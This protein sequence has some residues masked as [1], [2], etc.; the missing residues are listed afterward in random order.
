MTENPMRD[1]D[2]PPGAWG[3]GPGAGAGPGAWGPG[4]WA[5]AGPGDG[6]ALTPPPPPPPG[7]GGDS[8]SGATPPGASR[9]Q[10]QPPWRLAALLA[11][12]AVAAGGAGAGI[13]FAFAGA[14]SSPST[15]PLPTAAPGNAAPGSSSLDVRGIVAKIEPATVDITATGPLGKDEG[16]GMVL[17]ASGV[18]LTNNHVINGSTALTA[19]VD[20]TG[21]RYTARVLGT[22]TTEDVALLALHGGHGFKTVTIGDSSSVSVGDQVVAIGN[23][24]ALPGPETVTSGIISATHRSISV[25]DPATQASENL[26]GLFQ[27]SAAISS[28]NSGG[29]LVDSAGRVIGM[30]TAAASSNGANITASNVGFAIPINKAMSIARQVQAGHASATVQIGPH[31][32]MGVDVTTVACAEGHAPNCPGLGAGSFGG[33]P[34]GAGQYTAPVSKGAVVAGVVDGSPAAKAGLATGDVI[35]SIDGSRVSSNQELVS[36]MNLHRVGQKV[37]V[38]WVDQNGHHHSAAL[39]L[40]KGANA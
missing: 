17:T 15:G 22:D 26:Q 18:V 23:A 25:S 7:A 12:T 4:P 5:G 34:F 27:T 14:S 21:K 39:S 9:P 30:N 2:R 19:R 38:G 33:F 28:G 16:T 31:A 24:L 37:T 36:T 11:A 32:I 6:R 10:R 3:P 1:D 8:S 40:V 20:G 35:T 13:T 29:P